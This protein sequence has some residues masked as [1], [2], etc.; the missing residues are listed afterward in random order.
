MREE[1]DRRPLVAVFL[2]LAAGSAAALAGWIALLALPVALLAKRWPVRIAVLA[3]CG[4]GWLHFPRLSPTQV[5]EQG[6]LEGDV[7]V[8]TM[9]VTTGHALRSIAQYKDSRYVLYL[10]LSANVVLGNRVHVRAKVL[11][12]REGQLADRGATG[13]MDAISEPR[14]LSGGTPLWRLGLWVRRSFQEFTDRYAAP[15]TGP[16]IDAMCFSMTSDLSDDFRKGMSGTGTNH[17][18][19]TSGL[20]VVL[21]SFAMAALLGSLPFPRPAQL[22]LL[23]LMMGVYA[24]AAGFQAPVVRAILMSFTFLVAYLLRRGPDGLSALAFAGV[25]SLLWAPELVRD[26][27]FQLSM[28][29]VGSIVLFVRQAET[30]LASGLGGLREWALRYV[31]ASL[32]VTLATAPVLAYHFGRVPLMSLPANLLVVPVLGVV[33]SGALAAWSLWLL[34]PAVGV[35]ALKF[36]VEP[37]TGWVG[38]VIERLGLL[39][40]ASLEVPDFSA[41]WLLPFYLAAVLLWRP[42]VRTP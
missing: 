13:V 29:A 22:G 27:G 4:F 11:P 5:V 9:P 7:D 17:I 19:S 21:V 40:F 31:E 42:Y 30:T 6:F 36:C 15:E 23:A 25:L 33:V 18:V 12:L 34:A 32:V 20:H 39:P 35:G 37:C 28:V 26:V 2:G 38:L 41:Y 10:P 14:V 16:L 24:A 1:L 3:A 8:I